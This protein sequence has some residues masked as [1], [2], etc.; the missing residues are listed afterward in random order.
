MITLGV[1]GALTPAP[2]TIYMGIPSLMPKVPVILIPQQGDV[3]FAFCPVYL[4]LPQSMPPPVRW[5]Y[6]EGG[7]CSEK[8]AH[9]K[10]PCRNCHPILQQECEKKWLGA[11]FP[12]EKGFRAQHSH[13]ATVPSIGGLHCLAH[14]S[15]TRHTSHLGIESDDVRC[16]GRMTASPS[17][18]RQWWEFIA[19]KPWWFKIVRLRDPR[20]Q[21]WD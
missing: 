15:A 13:E 19:G 8:W 12:P 1:R 4:L 21:G 2:K 17:G 16:C 10:E 7:K 11:I 20:V 3:P 18:R 14:S 6:Q 9:H 5:P